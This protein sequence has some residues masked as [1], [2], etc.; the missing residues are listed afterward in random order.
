LMTLACA[1]TTVLILRPILQAAVAEASVRPWNGR[2]AA[3]FAN[4]F[5]KL[6]KK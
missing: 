1:Y 2:N 3:L 5:W 6:Q 4:T